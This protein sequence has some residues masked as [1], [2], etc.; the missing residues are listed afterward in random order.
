M[1]FVDRFDFGDKAPA[2]A[3][4]SRTSTLSSGSP[5]N[6]GSVLSFP[7]T[8]GGEPPPS[9]PSIFTATHNAPTSFSPDMEV[10][11]LRTCL[12]SDDFYVIKASYEGNY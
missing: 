4:T 11:D 7:S 1:L 9:S 3:S 5:G 12:D 6:R 2:Q 8:S 10:D